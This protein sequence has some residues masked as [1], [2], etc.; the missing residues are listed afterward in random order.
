MSFTAG[1]SAKNSK[2]K[3]QIYFSSFTIGRQ[4]LSATFQSL[5][6]IF[7]E[8]N[9]NSIITVTYFSVFNKN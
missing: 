9:W 4:K 8:N 1:V 7:H 5:Y 3:M 6:D 2:E